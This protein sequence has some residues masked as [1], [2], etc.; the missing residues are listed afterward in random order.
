[1]H[2]SGEWPW[3]LALAA[4]LPGIYLKLPLAVRGRVCSK[5]GTEN[6]G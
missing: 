3:I 1:L 4:S 6:K 2:T 5:I